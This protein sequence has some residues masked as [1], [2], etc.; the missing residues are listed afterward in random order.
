MLEI[1]KHKALFCL[2]LVATMK[3]SMVI[4]ISMYVKGP[5]LT[6][7]F[8]ALSSNDHA[9]RYNSDTHPMVYP[10]LALAGASSHH[11]LNFKY[12]IF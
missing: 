9:L 5:S 7:Q 10:D 4:S 1:W 6:F 12:T 3:S 2:P 8:L 11:N